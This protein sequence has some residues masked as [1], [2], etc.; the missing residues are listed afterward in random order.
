MHT[1]AFQVLRLWSE[2]VCSK[3]RFQ[4]RFQI[5]LPAVNLSQCRKQFG[6]E[7][8]RGST[9]RKALQ[10]LHGAMKKML[11]LPYGALAAVWLVNLL[12]RL[13]RDWK[14]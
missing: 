10:V 3:Y 5:I 11:L 1:A 13:D 7:S 14:V 8:V 9:S 6:I 12:L 2:E 4:S